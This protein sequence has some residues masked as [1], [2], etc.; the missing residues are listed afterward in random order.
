MVVRLPSKEQTPVRFR[1]PAFGF[2]PKLTFGRGS[3]PKGAAIPPTRYVDNLKI[4][5]KLEKMPWLRYFFDK[6]IHGDK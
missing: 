6:V 5:K 1:Y 3:P 2:P 4:L